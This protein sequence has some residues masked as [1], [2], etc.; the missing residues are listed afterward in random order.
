MSSFE[1]SPK[2]QRRKSKKERVIQCTAM[3]TESIGGFCRSMS[4]PNPE[5]LNLCDKHYQVHADL[6]RKISQK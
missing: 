1:K 6:V 5:G 2:I 4:A 3:D